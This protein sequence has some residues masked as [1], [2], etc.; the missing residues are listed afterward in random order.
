[1]CA[2]RLYDSHMYLCV[3]MCIYDELVLCVGQ[4][5]LSSILL[6]PPLTLF[7]ERGFLPELG[8]CQLV[9]LASQ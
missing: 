3:C 5:L 6:N 8:V 9:I 2:Y 7:F 1:M 4:I